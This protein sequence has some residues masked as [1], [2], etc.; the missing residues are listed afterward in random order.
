[1]KA[2]WVSVVS[3]SATLFACSGGGQL[4]LA[5]GTGTEPVPG[6]HGTILFADGE[7]VA[8]NGQS[9]DNKESR[10]LTIVFLTDD[11]QNSKA[12]GLKSSSGGAVA[13]FDLSEGTYP[14][15]TKCSIVWDK[16]ADEV[17]I[18]GAKYSRKN[19]T[20]FVV[21][22]SKASKSK[23]WQLAPPVSMIKAKDLMTF[24]QKELTDVP[25]VQA[26]KPEAKG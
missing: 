19:G 25:E 13:T 4:Y 18:D 7:R 1:M 21:V 20:L 16:K 8:S 5:I 14:N 10:L 2:R 6:N 26:A 9:L 17:D 23:S 3:L 15:E 12:S 22:K 24:A 11:A